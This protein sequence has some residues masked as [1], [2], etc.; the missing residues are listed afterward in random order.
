MP[1]KIKVVWFTDDIDHEAKGAATY[2]RKLLEQLLTNFK[3]QIDLTLIHREGKCLHPVCQLTKNITIKTFKTKYFSGLLSWAW[4]FLTHKEKFDIF[5]VPR[6]NLY[7]F[8]FISRWRGKIKKFICTLHGAPDKDTP[9]I[10]RKGGTWWNWHIKYFAKYFCDMFLAGAKEGQKQIIEYY[11]IKPNKTAYF[12]ISCNDQFRQFSA[13]EKEQAK[14][15]LKEK[16]GIE[17]PYFLQVGRMDP[18]KNVHR[19]IQ[20]FA[21][22]KKEYQV[23]HTLIVVGGRHLKNYSNKVDETI[24]ENHLEDSVIVTPFIDNQDMP[25][26]YNLCDLYTY[27]CLNDGFSIPLVEAMKT[28]ASIVTSNMSVFP[29]VAGEAGYYVDP[30]NPQ[31]IADGIWKML[32]DERLRNQLVQKGLERGKIFNWHQAAKDLVEIYKQVLTK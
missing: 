32:N 4:F 3:D 9:V 30:F 1:Q 12:Y 15:R 11:G 19:L 25:A 18:H 5:H 26:L 21:I 6:H 27:V 23:P 31:D 2:T 8:F 22:L 10:F 29:E 20:A 24:K 17:P 14:T 28:G 7:P 16:Y 13:E